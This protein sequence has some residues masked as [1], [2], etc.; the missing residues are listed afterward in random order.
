MKTSTK[1]SP[2]FPVSTC[3][4]K[5]GG[6]GRELQGFIKFNKTY[7]TSC[8][9]AT[10]W[11]LILGWACL[12]GALA[13]AGLCILPRHATGR[14][15]LTQAAACSAGA[16]LSQGC[17]SPAGATAALTDAASF[18]H[19]QW[20]TATAT[21]RGNSH[22]HRVLICAKSSLVEILF[23]AAGNNSTCYLHRSPSSFLSV[24][25]DQQLWDLRQ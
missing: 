10:W 5:T 18:G 25:C 23:I 12:A 2:Q 11:L 20:T 16:R 15:S 6:G 13:V 21:A 4:D 8:C 19:H 24:S 1:S 14:R 3:C 9:G 22:T 7:P 17:C